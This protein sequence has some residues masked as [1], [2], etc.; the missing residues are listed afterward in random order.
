MLSSDWDNFLKLIPKDSEYFKIFSKA[1]LVNKGTYKKTLKKNILVTNSKILEIANRFRN[2]LVKNATIQEKI[3]RSFLDDF[4]IKH[5]YQKIELYGNKFYIV[6]FYLPEYN[7]V[8]EIDGNHHYTDEY[9]LADAERTAHLKT[10]KIKEVYRIKNK[11]CT[12]PL[13]IKWWED[14]DLQKVS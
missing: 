10:L 3:F 7:C 5:L 13:L 2:K 6:D 1:L 4:K 9:L 8:I 11:D 12:R 14:L